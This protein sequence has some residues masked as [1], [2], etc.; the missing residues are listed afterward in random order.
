MP[1]IL[2]HEVNVGFGWDEIKNH[3]AASYVISTSPSKHLSQVEGFARFIDCL[4]IVG[5]SPILIVGPPTVLIGLLISLKPEKGRELIR[6][7]SS[8]FTGEVFFIIPFLEQFSESS[9]Q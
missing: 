5:I 7:S 2:R 6:H 8:L 3:F 1:F 4:R 9:L